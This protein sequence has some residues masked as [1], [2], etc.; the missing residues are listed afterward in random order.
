MVFLHKMALVKS[1]VYQRFHF[2]RLSSSR[3]GTFLLLDNFFSTFSLCCAISRRGAIGHG[4]KGGANDASASSAEEE[5]EEGQRCA[6]LSPSSPRPHF[7]ELNCLE[8]PFLARCLPPPTLP[9]FPPLVVLR[10]YASPRREKRKK[11]KRKESKTFACVLLFRAIQ[12][13]TKIGAAYPRGAISSSYLFNFGP[14]IEILL[15]KTLS[16]LAISAPVRAYLFYATPALSSQPLSLS[17]RQS[18]AIRSRFDPPLYC[19]L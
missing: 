18:N 8:R 4:E 13:S 6:I 15:P 9:P 12:D 1:E 14:N 11:K 16:N 7:A 10:H 19:T 5:E 2:E 17:P 3:K